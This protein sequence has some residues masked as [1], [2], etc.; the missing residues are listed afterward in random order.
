M[1]TYNNFQNA[2]LLILRIITAAIFFVAAYFKFPFWSAEPEGMSAF[3]LFT[4]RLLSIAEPLGAFAV[5][6]GFLTR[7]AAIGLTIIMIG[8]IFVTQFVFGIGFVT[9]TGP[10]WDMPLMVLAGCLIL[11]TFGAG[12]WSIDGRK[13]QG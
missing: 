11:L 3:L 6:I 10:G 2:A 5:L 12:A 4:T 1:H 13:K 7:W 8:A 9:Q